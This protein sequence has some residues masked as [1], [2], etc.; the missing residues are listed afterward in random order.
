MSNL[1]PFLDL[2]VIHRPLRNGILEGFAELIDTGA[3]TN[4]PAVHKFEH[5]FAGFCGRQHCVGVASGLDALRLGL[6]AAGL[7]S[8]DE[9]IVPANTFI[10]TFEA[11]TQASGLPVPA[12]ASENDYNLDPAAVEAAVSGRTRFI[13]PVHLYGQLADMRAIA[14]I[15]ERRGLRIVEDACQAHAASRDGVASGDL[16][17]AAAFSFYP[18]KN[19]GA[20]GD[21]GAVVCDDRE[22]AARVIGL[23][24]HGQRA[25]Y[26]H[27]E[28][29]YTARLDTLQ[30]LIL[31]RKLPFLEEWT[32]ARRDVAR[33]YSERLQG[34]G[35]LRLPPVAEGSEPAWYVYVIRT[36]DPDGL[37]GFLSG[38]G[39]GTGRHY[40]E[41]VHLSAAYAY[42]GYRP[43]SFPVAETLCA[44][45][46]SL[47]IYPG[48][49]EA[50]L[51]AVVSAVEAY[52]AGG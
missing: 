52:F 21:A 38:R 23:R 29:G 17:A 30:A 12:D 48:I 36:Q 14:G 4:G 40:P 20:M 51:D 47:P 7:Q 50:Q 15:A 42:L 44:E 28:P 35:D 8:G 37:A 18:S 16:S 27:D 25:K 19:L 1:V 3:F 39:I 5:A 6:I 41:P 2:G 9:V 46:L 31:L 24:E 45:C 32:A 26:R 10:A 49:T 33:Y 11:V 34:V 22:L 13:L 43:C